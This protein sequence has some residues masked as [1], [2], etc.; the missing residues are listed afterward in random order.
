MIISYVH[1]PDN[2]FFFTEIPAQGLGYKW[3]NR[4][5]IEHR[6][7]ASPGPQLTAT[8]VNSAIVLKSEMR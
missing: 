3:L 1:C 7:P 8:S 2:R 6:R 5:S 4:L